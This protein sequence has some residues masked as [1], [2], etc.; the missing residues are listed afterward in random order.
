[1]TITTSTDAHGRRAAHHLPELLRDLGSDDERTEPDRPD[2]HRGVPPSDP[3]VCYGHAVPGRL[4][5]AGR[6]GRAVGLLGGG[7]G[8][9]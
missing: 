8:R 2:A 6:E 7:C 4:L 5:V 1:M 9:G 3:G